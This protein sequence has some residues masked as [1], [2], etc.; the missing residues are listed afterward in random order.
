MKVVLI[1]TEYEQ[2]KQTFRENEK[3]IKKE[4]ETQYKTQIINLKRINE[5]QEKAINMQEKT[6]NQYKEQLEK[7]T[8]TTHKY[9]GLP[10]KQ[11][12]RNP[13]LKGK[14]DTYIKIIQE[15]QTK[16][17]SK[18]DMEQDYRKT[19]E[20]LRENIAELVSY[21]HK[22]SYTGLKLLK[23]LDEAKDKIVQQKTD[24]KNISTKQN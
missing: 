12:Y 2:I 23:E 16:L 5:E 24:A 7:A 14:E 22:Q 13:N 8:K 4:I 9:K 20:D 6:I 17:Q 3:N 11:D 18:E 15:L 1:I 19:I 10:R 21:N